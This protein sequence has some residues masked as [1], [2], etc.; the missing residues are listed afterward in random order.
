MRRTVLLLLA[1]LAFAGCGGGEE[2]AP[3][4]ETVV[5]ELATEPENQGSPRGNAE[6]GKPIFEQNCGTC[7]VL[8]AAGTT[9]TAGPNLDETQT[10]YEEA[11]AQIRNGGDGMP[12]FGGQLSDQ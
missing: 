9:G 11:V 3:T 10:T 12:P 7:H 5:G 8:E 6:A 2:A 1:L 4:A